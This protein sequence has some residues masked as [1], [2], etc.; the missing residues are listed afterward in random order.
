MKILKWDILFVENVMKKFLHLLGFI[1]E[2]LLFEALDQGIDVGW[3]GGV[4]FE[5]VEDT[6]FEV[7]DFEFGGL[8]VFG[9]WDGVNDGV[10]ILEVWFDDGL[11]RGLVYNLVLCHLLSLYKIL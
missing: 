11:L 5:E 1:E 7:F 10:G 9:S 3:L 8:G 2:H 4:D 6:I